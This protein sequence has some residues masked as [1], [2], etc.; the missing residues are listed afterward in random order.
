MIEPGRVYVTF[1]SP[2][3]ACLDTATGKVIW[4]RRDIIVNHF[5]GAGS[6]PADLE[7]PLIMDLTAA[8]TSSS[9]RS[10]RRPARRVW[11]TDRS[12]DFK[13]LDPAGKPMADGDMR[14]AF[15]TLRIATFSDPDGNPGK[16][17]L[18]S[19]GSK[20]LYA[21]DPATGKEIWRV[22][23]RSAHSGSATPVIGTT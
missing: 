8:T 6:S 17:I 11:K 15:S 5:R 18:I 9:S 23:N 7:R 3:T 2:G 20:A 14:K 21:Y 1:G 19:L 22:E 4:Q 16:P 12:I 13:D 10:T